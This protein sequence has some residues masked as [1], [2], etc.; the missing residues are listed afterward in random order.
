MRLVRGVL[1]G[2]AGLALPVLVDL[3]LGP[4]LGGGVLLHLAVY[5]ALLPGLGVAL[6]WS[7]GVVWR[8]AAGALLMLAAPLAALSML[9]VRVLGTVPTTTLEALPADALAAGFRLPDAAPDTGL[10]RRVNPQAAAGATDPRS[11]PSTPATEPG[12][13]LVAPVFG[14][15][16]SRVNPVRVVAVQDLDAGPARPWAPE[17]GV[18]KLRPDAAREAAVRQALAEAGVAAGPG[19]LVGRW[20][21]DPGRARLE[22]AK[23]FLLVLGGGVLVWTG[24]LLAGGAAPKPR[25]RR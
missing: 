15:G 10:Q 8:L 21:A 5:L 16:W 1:A 2:V 13:Y 4:L 17:G 12:A 25:R 14:P 23:P 22:A 6:L 11:G 9:D 19:L 7:E 18:L 24:L 20:V 3:A